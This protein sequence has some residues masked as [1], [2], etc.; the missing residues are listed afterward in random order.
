MKTSAFFPI[1]IVALTLVGSS[2]VADAD[3]PP[4]QPVAPDT[5]TLLSKPIVIIKLRPNDPLPNRP[6]APAM[7][8]ICTYSAG[9]YI[10][11]DGVP[12]ENDMLHVTVSGLTS[13]FVTEYDANTYEPIYIGAIT[14]DIEINC[15]LIPSGKTYAGTIL[16]SDIE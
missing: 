2:V 6:K 10:W 5:T 16:L 11:F 12:G 14:E 1:V 4:T 7:P 3:N 8:I 15:T 13:G 9:G